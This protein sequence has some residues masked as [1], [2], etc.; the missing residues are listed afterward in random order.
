MPKA[1][2]KANPLKMHSGDH[3]KVTPGH[4]ETTTLQ[5]DHQGADRQQIGSVKAISGGIDRSSR[6][7]AGKKFRPRTSNQKRAAIK[8]ERFPGSF[9]MP[10]IIARDGGEDRQRKEKV[11]RGVH[12]P[13]VPAL[14]LAALKRT[15]WQAG[16]R[17]RHA[18]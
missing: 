8:G 15:P 4:A 2:Q 17:E 16:K 11:L 18:I 12:Q 1:A 6:T 5:D 3:Q 7:A 14:P 9:S 13:R 10:R